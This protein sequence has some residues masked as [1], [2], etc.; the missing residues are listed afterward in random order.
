MGCT[1]SLADPGNVVDQLIVY[2]GSQLSIDMQRVQD[3]YTVKTETIGGKSSCPRRLC[4]IYVRRISLQAA[5]LRECQYSC[6]IQPESAAPKPT[7][8][9]SSQYS[10]VAVIDPPCPSTQLVPSACLPQQYL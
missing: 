2:A 6:K 5:S 3:L 1:G 7:V 9:P 4:N 8:N 10:I